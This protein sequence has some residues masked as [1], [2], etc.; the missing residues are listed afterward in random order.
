MAGPAAEFNYLE[1]FKEEI[2]NENATIKIGAVNN[3]HLIASALGP[4]RTVSELLPYMTQVVQE[5][6]LC[7]DDEFLHSMAKQFA[8]LS[9]Y[10]NGHDELLIAPLEHLADQEETVIREQAIQSLIKVIEKRPQLAPDHLVPTLHRLATK[11]DFFTARVSACAL[12]PLAYRHVNAD[13]KQGLRKAFVTLCGGETPMVRRAAAHKMRD[14][15]QVCEKQDLLTDLISVYTQLSQEDTQDTIRVA[16]VHATLV[17]ARMLNPEE[18]RQHTVERIKD[19]VE[20]RSWRVR[21]TVAKN[22][23]Q[24]CEA[25][26][27]ELT[28]QKLMTPF[29]QLMKDNEQEVRKEAVKIIEPCLKLPNHFT[30]EQLQQHILP[31]FQA[32]GMDS[33]Q[34][35]KAALAQVLGPIA[36]ALGRDVTQRQLLT[37]ISD[38]MKDEFHD[39]RLNI[40]SHAGLVCEV[41]GAEGLVHSLLHTVQN[42]IMDNHWRIRQSVVE[43]VPRLSRLFGMELFQTKLEAIF[44]S[45]LRD[46]V[47]SV[48][49]SATKHISEIATAFGPQWT[50][51]H[52]LPKLV[53]QY[54][55][56]VGYANRVTTLHVLPQVSCVMTPE[57]VNQYIVPLLV[58]ATKDSVPNVRFCACR[59]IMWM[60]ENHN[61]GSQALSASVKP[62]LLELEHDSDI[63]VQY[64]AQ[65][66]LL[67]CN[68]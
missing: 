32:L 56:S 57:Q 61:L 12:L 20:D 60:M 58:K 18:N 34:S 66:A 55:E 41:L 59:T 10:I 4:Q 62:A 51:E 33:A 65:R 64:Y 14:F 35:V 6:P 50:V 25:F 15:I 27:P 17:I 53:E 43:Q 49:Q 22:F 29:I 23:D 28:A 40:V 16:C 26:G 39:V 38:L 31:Q 46:S 21:L 24:L 44:L 2:R 13:Q 47:H 42:L 9:E 37:L 68:A 8:V 19:A 54:S 1:F 30:P 52:L 45:S 48:R 5:E 36:K 7:N 63:D 11:T 67:H 3:L